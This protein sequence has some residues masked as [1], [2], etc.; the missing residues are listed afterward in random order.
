MQASLNPRLV[1]ASSRTDLSDRRQ[2]PTPTTTAIMPHTP[3][4]H[5]PQ[6]LKQAKK[7]YRKSGGTV[8]LSES[9]KALLERRAVLQERADRI[10]ER[11]ARR[12]ANIK[13][14]DERLQRE[15]EARHRMGIPTPPTKEGIQVGPSQL[16]LSGFVYAGTKR[17]REEGG[18]E[19]QEI[20]A[21]IQKQGVAEEQQKCLMEQS[22]YPNPSPQWMRPSQIANATTPKVRDIAVQKDQ[23]SRTPLQDKSAN[24]T[25]QQKPLSGNGNKIDGLRTQSSTPQPPLR[26]PVTATSTSS[27]VFK[28]PLPPKPEPIP[29][30][31][32]DDFFVSNT[33]IQRELSPPPTPPTKTTSHKI[34][35]AR[36]PTP[37][38]P[39]SFKPLSVNEDTANLLAF[40]S[41][42]DLDFTDEL[43]QLIPE[44]VSSPPYKQLIANEAAEEQEQEQEE[45]FPDSE[46]EDLVLEFSLESPP[47]PPPPIR[48]PNATTRPE[49][50]PPLHT[51]SHHP[52]Y[53]PSNPKIPSNLLQPISKEVDNDSRKKESQKYKAAAAAAAAAEWDA[54]NLLS[55]QDLLELES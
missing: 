9:E 3:L 37:S 22:L 15:R 10:K 39:P 41:T 20:E 46:L 7:A 18:A 4:S 47:P 2:S 36:P 21:G 19:G 25:V 14:K 33:Q 13:K 50:R 51:L 6:T 30:D 38:F 1:H 26:P 11:E 32:F 35:T 27:I 42:Q 43:T 45:D 28:K 55:T 8:R 44:P 17:K 53:Y 52:T 54:F 34:S 48:S 31:C 5:R 24:P 40:I 23:T 12:K 49:S 16:H 29:D